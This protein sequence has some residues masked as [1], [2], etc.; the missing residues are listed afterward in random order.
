MSQKWYE[1]GGSRVFNI[2]F[3][4]FMAILI[5][6]FLLDAVGVFKGWVPPPV[7][8]H[9]STPTTPPNTERG[10]VHNYDRPLTPEE[11]ELARKQKE[12]QLIDRYVR[13]EA[14]KLV[15]KYHKR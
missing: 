13:R 14:E 3:W 9:K 8:T 6:L 10:R 4:S 11:K 7:A 2:I 12:E 15:E 1:V 5:G